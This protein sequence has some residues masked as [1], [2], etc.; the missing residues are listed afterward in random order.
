MQQGKFL[1]DK[2]KLFLQWEWC[3]MLESTSLEIFKSVRPWTTG[4]SFE[5]TLAWTVIS[6]PEISSSLRGSAI[7]SR[8]HKQKPCH[9]PTV[10]SLPAKE[11]VNRL[12]R[13]FLLILSRGISFRLWCSQLFPSLLLWCPCLMQVSREWNQELICSYQVFLN[14]EGLN[15]KPMWWFNFIQD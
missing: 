9:V 2:R 4:S 7:A 13:N 1:L 10:L 8:S 15:M 3:I 5:I 6:P 11:A 12:L 14:T